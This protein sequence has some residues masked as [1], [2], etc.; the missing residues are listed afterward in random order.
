MEPCQT[1]GEADQVTLLVSPNCL[2]GRPV[3]L[4]CYTAQPNGDPLE[5]LALPRETMSQVLARQ[6]GVVHERLML[7]DLRFKSQLLHLAA[8]NGNQ[9]AVEV[10]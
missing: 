2:A 6:P 10:W 3:C 5:I 7:T 9:D 8:E 4:R 1:C